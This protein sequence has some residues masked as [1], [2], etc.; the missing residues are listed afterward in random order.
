[1]FISMHNHS[2]HVTPEKFVFWTSTLYT[3]LHM[4]VNIR[5]M[6]VEC[7][8][9]MKGIFLAWQLY[10]EVQHNRQTR[11]MQSVLRKLLWGNWIKSCIYKA[12]LASGPPIWCTGLFFYYLTAQNL[13]FDRDHLRKVP[14]PISGTLFSSFNS[15]NPYIIFFFAPPILWLLILKKNEV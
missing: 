12:V 4:G 2:P 15:C 14:K 6:G 5:T 1:M 13:Y 8:L 3:Q 9:Y 11:G 7:G 10:V